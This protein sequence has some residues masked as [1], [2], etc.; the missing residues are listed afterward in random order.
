MRGLSFTLT[1]DNPATLRE[2]LSGADEGLRESVIEQLRDTLPQGIGEMLVDT[3]RETRS[4]EITLSTLTDI[5]YARLQ[6]VDPYVRAVSLYALGQ[7]GATTSD[8]LE[9]FSK[10]EHGLVRETALRLRDRQTS[11][12]H[13]ELMTVEKMIAL[14]SA[15][16]FSRLAPEGLA[17][18]ASESREAELTPGAN[19]CR[20]GEPGN[21]VFILVDGEV[22]VVAR[23]GAGE[24]VVSTERA[25]AFIGELAVL[26]PAPRSAGLRAGKSGARVL[27]LDGEAF[28]YALKAE[29]S[30]ASHVIRTLAQRLRRRESKK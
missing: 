6:S 1:A 8:I 17:E 16:I 5:L 20:E 21:E 23:D 11:G 14:R 29:P 24:N 13:P 28:N 19:L 26:D 2:A 10:D 3:F 30:I 27:R 7:R 25:G 4:R 15:P 9:T 22:E 18:L 12:A